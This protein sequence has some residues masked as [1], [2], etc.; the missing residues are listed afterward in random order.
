[1]E[2][3]KA[4][5]ACAL[6][7]ES[8]KG[9]S[10]NLA[11]RLLHSCEDV[12]ALLRDGPDR[13]GLAA[14]TPD[15][16]LSLKKAHKP[17]E[18]LNRLR[19]IEKSG[20]SL[21]LPEHPLFPER[22]TTIEDPPLL[23]YARGN[24][25]LLAHSR[26]LAVVGTRHPT[27]YGLKVTKMLT[28]AAVEQGAMIISGL[29]VGIDALAHLT[30]LENEGPTLAVMGC[31]LDINYPSA[32][33]SLRKRILSSG[34]GLILSEKPPGTPAYPS[35]FP[36][37]N[38]LISGLSAGLIVVEAVIKSGTMSTALHGI[39][40]GREVFAVPGN[41]DAPQSAGTNF[42]I[43][44]MAQILTT[45]DDLFT[46]LDWRIPKRQR[47]KLTAEAGQLL[48]LV[49]R[50]GD[51]TID[52]FIEATGWPAGQLYEFLSELE[53]KRLIRCWFGRYNLS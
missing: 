1:M 25:E 43:Q 36:D 41:I 13:L 16:R 51:L 14:L 45:P 33:A 37:R 52:D 5:A 21:I 34:D 44:N 2:T 39:Q 20:M 46:R 12:E 27:Q 28:Q 11:R 50:Y 53:I 42:L 26:P 32:N 48:A 15:Q 47:P 4:Y 10:R 7:M 49:E 24:L 38:R 3:C 31:G 22:L 6:W 8:S 40:Q 19:Q 35:F 18:I 23:L 17:D 9:I 29:A 30:A